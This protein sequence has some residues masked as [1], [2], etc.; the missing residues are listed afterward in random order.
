MRTLFLTGGIASGKSTAA[1]ELERLGALRIDLDQLSRE[2][3]EPGSPAHHAVCA[4]FGADLRGQDGRLRRDLLAQRV[5]GD[6]AALQRLEQ[7]E[8]PWI[9]ARC[10]ELLSETQ[11]QGCP[12]AVVEVPLLDRALAYDMVPAGA[13]LV[14]VRVPRELRL[15]R[16]VGRGTSAEDFAARDARQ[17]SDAYL[18]A[19]A[20]TILPNE[21]ASDE[22][23]AWARAVWDEACAAA[24]AEAGRD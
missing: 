5:F 7:I 17:P 12:C 16:A 14:Y 10:R 9:G 20:T 2:A 1:R 4:E 23:V 15:E 13:E 18:C 11:A 24:S 6:P 8:L 22:L 21:G 19:H 3:L